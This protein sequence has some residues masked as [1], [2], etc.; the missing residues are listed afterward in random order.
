MTMLSSG[1]QIADVA[2]MKMTGS[3]GNAMPDSFA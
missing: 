1:P 2:F 3:T